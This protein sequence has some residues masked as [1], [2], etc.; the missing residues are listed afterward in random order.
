MRMKTTYISSNRTIQKQSINCQHNLQET[1]PASFSTV[2]PFFIFLAISAMGLNSAIAQNGQQPSRVTGEGSENVSLYSGRL[3]F[4]LPLTTSGGRGGNSTTLNLHIKEK[5]WNILETSRVYDGNGNLAQINYAARGF[6]EINPANTSEYSPMSINVKGRNN[7]SQFL[8]MGS[9]V[10]VLEIFT[11]DGNTT[12]LRDSLI[13]GQIRDVSP[14]GFGQPVQCQV[15]YTWGNWFT[16]TALPP[17]AACSRGKIFH[18]ADGSAMTFVADE[19]IYDAVYTDMFSGWY[20]QQGG[21]YRQGRVIH[22]IIVVW[23]RSVVRNE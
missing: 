15:Q 20:L 19:D 12:V 1:K 2:I 17:A 22:S 4:N 3:N 13:N 14:L 18:S 7:I 21:W 16:L 23:G 9:A 10:T 11:N 5:P 8:G 6:T